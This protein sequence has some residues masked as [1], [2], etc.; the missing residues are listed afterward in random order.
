MLGILWCSTFHSETSA[1]KVITCAQ[2]AVLLWNYAKLNQD[3]C[4]LQEYYNV[5]KA[6]GRFDFDLPTRRSVTRWK[7][8]FLAYGDLKDRRGRPKDSGTKA[9]PQLIEE[10]RRLCND[11]RTPTS[12]RLIS[13]EPTVQ[14][15]HWMVA[16][17][18]RRSLKYKPY[19]P[20]TLFH[21][22]ES[23]AQRIQF[24]QELIEGTNNNSNHE[25]W[26]KIIFSDESWFTT[27]GWVNKHNTVYYAAEN[28]RHVNYAELHA[29]KIMVICFIGYNFK[30]GPFFFDRSLDANT[31]IE[32][33]NS[34]FF[35]HTVMEMFAQNRRIF[36]QDGAPPHTAR[37][38][39]DFL[40]FK[41]NSKWIG[42]GSPYITWPPHSPDLTPMDFFL[43]GHLKQRVYGHGISYRGNME[44]L[45]QTIIDE[46]NRIDQEIINKACVKE[47]K[48]RLDE[49]IKQNGD[50]ITHER[51]N[52][53]HDPVDYLYLNDVESSRLLFQGLDVDPMEIVDEDWDQCDESESYM[54][55]SQTSY[56]APQSQP[57][58][59][60]RDKIA[61]REVENNNCSAL[62]TADKPN[63]QWQYLCTS[64]QNPGIIYSL[65]IAPKCHCV[66]VSANL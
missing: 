3:Y 30:A 16:K 19:H 47:F 58:Y 32:M 52:R 51:E 43:W 17:I 45:K 59:Y 46:F 13:Q 26:R 20:R 44:T 10:I 36:Q 38:T 31:Y 57:L 25:F 61:K 9:T 49:V 24:A 5:M 66:D 28:P 42:I 62:Y 12:L 8:K 40:N 6:Q 1:T 27:G 50:H 29:Q 56:E 7:E 39:R 63:H 41:T 34:S 23:H 65:Q 33:L 64:S 18:I 37:R 2:K 35:N 15:S 54:E 48:E 53:V 21:L 4:S 11:G 22:Y 60:A 55:T 14:I